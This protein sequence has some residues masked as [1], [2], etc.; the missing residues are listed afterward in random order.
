M[1]EDSTQPMQ[2]DIFD[3][4]RDIMLR[5]DVVDAL[6]RREAST[7]RAAWLIFSKEFPLDD[8]LSPLAVL[9]DAL[10]HRTCASF[11]DHGAASD[12]RRLLNSEIAPAA[13]R[14]F[15]DKAG[16]T[17]LAPLWQEMAQRSTQLSFRPERSED[18]AA[19]LWLLA[20]DWSAATDA[21]ARIESWRRIPTPLAWMAEARYR[22][23]GLEGAW[24]LLA[25]LAWLSPGRFD[26]LT[27]RLADPPLEKLRNG[28]DASFE[29][30]GE[31]ADLAWF[32]A[33]VLTEKPGLSRLLGET[34]HS[35]HSAP[36]QAMRL[37]LELLGLERQ[38][39][40]HDMVERRKALRDVHP[41]LYA[42]YMATR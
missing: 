27:K 17:W 31:V 34:Q 19:P 13:V 40:H 20:G 24:A 11:L 12:A 38:G 3:H 35:L 18:H 6:E 25:E 32:P 28:F 22:M 33:W 10:E 4:S 29:G 5:N 7:A 26:R 14:T 36:E 1:P 30:D 39:R 37:L 9:I 8:T 2:L 41:S 15:G 23:Y 21:V 42:A 16:A